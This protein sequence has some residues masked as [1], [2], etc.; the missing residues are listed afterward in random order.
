MVQPEAQHVAAPRTSPVPTW[1]SAEQIKCLSC[2]P[3]VLNQCL[4]KCVLHKLLHEQQS[5]VQAAS[6]TCKDN[7]MLMNVIDTQNIPASGQQTNSPLSTSLPAQ[8]QNGRSHRPL[9]VLRHR[10]YPSTPCTELAPCTIFA[11]GT[12]AFL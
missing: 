2:F 8:F 5:C 4:A 6:E 11:F 3:F 10:L 9:F 12:L 7:A 1:A